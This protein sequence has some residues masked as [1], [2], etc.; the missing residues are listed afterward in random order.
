MII[1]NKLF[2]PLAI[3]LNGRT[4]HLAPRETTIVHDNEIS[5]EIKNLAG[6]G[7]LSLRTEPIAEPVITRPIKKK[8]MKRKT[9]GRTKK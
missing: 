6:R 3:N 9:T 8:T 2:Q 5:K 7:Y 4:I 1:K